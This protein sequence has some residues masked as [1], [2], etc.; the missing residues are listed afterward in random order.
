[1]ASDEDLGWKL[2]EVALSSNPIKL[3]NILGQGASAVVYA[4]EYVLP[5]SCE[6]E[7]VVVKWFRVADDEH[8]E[9][10]R[11][12]LESL[13]SLVP[14]VPKLLGT[15]DDQRALILQPVG[16]HYASRPD[17]IQ[18]VTKAHL[19]DKAETTKFALSDAND[20]CSLLDI[21]AKIHDCGFIHR[22]IKPS[23][24]FEYNGK[25]YSLEF[26][27]LKLLDFRCFSTTLA[28]Q[29]LLILVV[30]HLVVL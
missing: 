7:E 4:G 12:C 20:F 9:I 17:E 30:S 10:E 27:F 11:T 28:L 8:Q 21:I 26:S 24:F 1:M 22:D 19:L 18:E 13:Y 23:N 14:L 15:S 25:V 5:E 6:I 16:R 2:P 3:L 29:F